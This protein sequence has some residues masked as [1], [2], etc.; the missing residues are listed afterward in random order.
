MQHDGEVPFAGAGGQHLVEG[1]LTG[2]LT[3]PL[4]E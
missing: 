3:L 2:G 4:H 1:E